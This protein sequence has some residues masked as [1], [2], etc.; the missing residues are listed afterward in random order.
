MCNSEHQAK[1]CEKLNF[2]FLTLCVY[3][4]LRAVL[5]IFWVTVSQLSQCFAVVFLSKKRLDLLFLGVKFKF[6]QLFDGGS[7][8]FITVSTTGTFKPQTLDLGLWNFFEKSGVEAWGWNVLTLGVEGH[9]NLGL[10]NPIWH[11][12]VKAPWYL[13]ANPLR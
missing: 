9:F 11:W 10:L 3:L 12:K 6:S 7:E 13:C 1:I 8:L 5:S 2:C 4:F